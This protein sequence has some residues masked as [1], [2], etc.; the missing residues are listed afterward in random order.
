MLANRVNE[1]STTT[2]TDDIT[3]DAA[4]TNFR[5]FTSQFATNQRFVYTIDNEAGEWETGIG[6]LSGSTTLVREA[7]QDG[8][9]STPVNFSAGTKQVYSGIS[10]QNLPAYPPVT[11]AVSGFLEQVISPHHTNYVT[12]YTARDER[13]FFNQYIN[14]HGDA[15]F[16]NFVL[17]VN[18]AG[19]AGAKSRIGIYLVDEATGLPTGD[20]YIES[21]NI[22]CTTTGLKV[23]PFT[24][25]VSGISQSISLPNRFFLA[26]CTNDTAIR[27][28]AADNTSGV[29]TW[30]PRDIK[31]TEPYLYQ[32]FSL[33]AA[34]GVAEMPTVG[35]ISAITQSPPIAGLRI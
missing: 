2:G 20:P 1:T 26:Y 7:P 27:V 21:D 6:Y 14:N 4:V 25:S 16:S 13:V 3:L 29:R 22:D 33:S 23:Q 5:T 32:L 28:T 19:A 8:S 15:V 35:T 17:Q 9:A 31:G 24:S 10:A 18:T 11:T 30:L 34:D 12:T